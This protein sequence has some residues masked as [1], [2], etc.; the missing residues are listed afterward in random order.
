MR[1]LPAKSLML[2]VFALTIG[3][4]GCASGGGGGSDG[5]PRR[6]T[7]RIVA[8]ELATL[9][10]LDC[11]QAI[12]RLRPN[13]LRT[14]GSSPPQILVDGSRQSGGLDLLRSYRAA[15][16]EEMRFISGTDATTRFG[17]GFDGGA[18]MLTT[19]R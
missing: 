2:V 19:R 10:Q 9:Q 3:L 18:I 4:A 13:W 14:R 6:S 7:N 15:D 12:Q 1:P 8:D 5:A 16:V 11:Y 17:T